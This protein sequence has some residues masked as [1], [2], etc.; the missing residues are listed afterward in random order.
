MQSA[1]TSHLP[2]GARVQ[3][4]DADNGAFLAMA[5]AGM[6]QATPHIQW[7][8]LLLAGAAVRRDFLAALEADPPAG[9]LLTNAQWPRWP[10]F[11]AADEWPQFQAL[12]TSHYDLLL[13][14][15]E[16]YIAWRFY[17]R[18]P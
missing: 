2:R 5:R 11:E 13:T 1:L 8:S 9:V 7:Y 15:G 10:G 6:R 16:D 4:L 14:G 17:L 3:M 18:T 12:L